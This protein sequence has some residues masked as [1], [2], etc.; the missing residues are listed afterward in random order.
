MYRVLKR[1]TDSEIKVVSEH[2]RDKARAM[3]DPVYMIDG[4]GE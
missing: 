3:I 1:M 2:S 4:M